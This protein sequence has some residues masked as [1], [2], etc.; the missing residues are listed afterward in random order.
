MDVQRIGT[1]TTPYL[2]SFCSAQ[3]IAQQMKRLIMVFLMNFAGWTV[4]N[5]KE[6]S[7]ME[8]QNTVGNIP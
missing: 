1:I 7:T 5:E 2:V 6:D 8:G 3:I 4:R